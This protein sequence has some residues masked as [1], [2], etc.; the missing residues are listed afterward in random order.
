MEQGDKKGYVYILV[1]PAF[2][3]FVKVGRTTKEPETRARELSLGSGVP[4]PYAVAWEALVTDCEH[5]ERLIHQQLAHARAR[6]DREFFAIPLKKAIAVASKIIGPFSCETGEP[7][8]EDALMHDIDTSLKTQEYRKET[9]KPLSDKQAE[10]AKTASANPMAIPSRDAV[11][12]AVSHIRVEYLDDERFH[13]VRCQAEEKAREL[14]NANLGTMSPVNI[15][16]FL[17]YMNKESIKGKTDLTRFGRHFTNIVA[18]H[19]CT[20][21]NQFNEWI[22]A[23]W[24]TE[25][26]AL[27]EVLANFLENAPIKG[28]GTL[29]P[30]FVLYL[31]MPS[32]FSIYTKTLANNLA[33]A[34]LH[35]QPGRESQYDSYTRFNHEVFEDLVKPFRLQPQEVD[36]VLSQLPTYLV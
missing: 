24:R 8:E 18:G 3:G 33:K 22:G 29:L 35:D 27:K 21:P 12:R 10:G 5:V 34:F 11:E 9:A 20:C 28:A 19:I 31:R 30:T 1:N 17:D 6:N 32:A 36:L 16:S 4:A 14:L 25:G 13:S 2:S 15:R 23:L 7:I 26:D